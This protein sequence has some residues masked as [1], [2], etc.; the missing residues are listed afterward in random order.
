MDIIKMPKTIQEYK[1][2]E[3]SGFDVWLEEL[4]SED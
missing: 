2:Q 1:N 3:V 4:S